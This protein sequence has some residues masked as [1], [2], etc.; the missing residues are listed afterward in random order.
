MRTLTLAQ[1]RRIAVGAQGLD[2]ARPGRVDVRHFRS[3]LNRLK[4]VQLDSVNVAVRAHYMPFFSRLGSYDRDAL[5][6]WINGPEVFE[7]WAHV[8]SILPSDELPLMRFR[9]DQKFRSKRVAKLRREHPGYIE[10]VL[11]E[12]TAH[13]PLTVSDLREPG[14]RTGPWWGLGKGKIALDHLYSTGALT[15]R[16][17]T[18]NFV[19][20]YD[21]PERVF[22]P[23]LLKLSIPEHEAHRQLLLKAVQAHGVGMLSEIADYFRLSNPEARPRLAELVD[24]GRIQEVNV[25]G[26][27][28]TAY[29]DPAARL[30]RASRGRALLAPFDRLIW[31]RDR[32][33]RLFDFRYRIEIYV[34]EPQ[35]EFGYYVYPFLL[36]GEL[37]ARV[38]LKADRKAGVLLVLGSFAEEGVDRSRVAGA[39]SQ[40]LS[41]M[42]GWLGLADVNVSRNGN[43]S[44]ELVRAS[45]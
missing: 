1:A 32:T 7:Y 35:R 29:L 26:W 22:E 15:I 14:E 27:K 43:L 42:S 40:E 30:P 25:E 5:D 34:P 31:H 18:P 8:A 3:V 28:Q 39:L 36:D 19:S 37:V 9:M 33:E 6:R 23:E 24:G 10:E 2:R 45:G 11:A 38:D 12:V 17:R 20:I 13:G 41:L 44:G 4:V 16:G 21:T